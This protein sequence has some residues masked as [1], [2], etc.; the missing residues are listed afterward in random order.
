MAHWLDE[1]LKENVHFWGPNC[2]FCCPVTRIR[3][4]QHIWLYPIDGNED[5]VRYRFC[6]ACGEKLE[7]K[8]FKRVHE[9]LYQWEN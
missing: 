7:N 4:E 3:M 1:K 8:E 6:P 5:P 9:Y 2:G